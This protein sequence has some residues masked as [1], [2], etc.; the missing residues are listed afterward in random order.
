[1]R[2][3][4]VGHLLVVHAR[5]LGQVVG[6]VEPRHDRARRSD[7]L[8]GEGGRVGTHVGDVAVLVQL[9]RHLHGAARTE[10]QLAVGFLLQGTG[11][12]RR[13]GTQRARRLLDRNDGPFAVFEARDKVTRLQFVQEEDVLARRDLAG[14]LVEVLAGG[15]ALATERHESGL[16]RAAAVLE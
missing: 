5:L 16:E 3:L 9:L 4:G 11:G 7:G 2:F 6:T 1:V 13:V 15:E 8:I 12:E 14:L 10:S